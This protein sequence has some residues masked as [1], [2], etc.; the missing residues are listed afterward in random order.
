MGVI[1]TLAMY[2]PQKNI[3]PIKKKTNT[4]SEYKVYSAHE[5]EIDA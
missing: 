4:C 1:P 3:L 5:I 2:S